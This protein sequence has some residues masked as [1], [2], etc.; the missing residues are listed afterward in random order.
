MDILWQG[1]GTEDRYGYEP[2]RVFEPGQVPQRSFEECYD[3]RLRRPGESIKDWLD[4]IH[5]AMLEV[6]SSL[7]KERIRR[8]EM[9]Y[10]SVRAFDDEEI[11]QYDRELIEYEEQL[12]T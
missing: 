11:V 3:E 1:G 5:M 12:S 4:A 8:R 9:G 7:K 10:A 2:P 6:P